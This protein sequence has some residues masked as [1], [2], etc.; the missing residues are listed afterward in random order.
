M[1]LQSPLTLP[2][3]R[4][5]KR[6]K[7]SPPPLKAG[8]DP[9]PADPTFSGQE[10]WVQVPIPPPNSVDP[11]WALSPEVM[12]AL[13]VLDEYIL[14][15]PDTQPWTGL[16][17]LDHLKVT[18]YHTYSLSQYGSSFIQCGMKQFETALKKLNEGGLVFQIQQQYG[19]TYNFKVSPLALQ[20]LNTHPVITAMRVK[21]RRQALDIRN[22]QTGMNGREV[23]Q[24]VLALTAVRVSKR[25]VHYG[26]FEISKLASNLNKDDA[27]FIKALKNQL[28]ELLAVGLLSKYQTH[29][30][31]ASQF[32][33]TDAGLAIFAP[34]VPTQGSP[35]ED[36]D[37]HREM[38]S[39]LERRILSLKTLQDTAR[40]EF[41]KQRIALEASV[42]QQAQCLAVFEKMNTNHKKE[43]EAAT[44]PI[45]QMTLREEI[46]DRD[47]RID[48][49]RSR[50]EHE[51]RQ[52]ANHIEET[53]FYDQQALDTLSLLEETLLVQKSIHAQQQFEATAQRME[54]QLKGLLS[55]REKQTALGQTSDPTWRQSGNDKNRPK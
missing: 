5:P 12:K 2:A 14:N 34:K 37:L 40:A 33:I 24:K 28:E 38:L 13:D 52:L 45:Q 36:A 48:R 7:T 55:E 39:E 11:A 44:D 30:T 35:P 3:Y 23:L 49:H 4:A 6:E 29:R 22:A 15:E 19:N 16:Q 9:P 41:Q 21:A 50:L 1:R 25:E 31:M 17:L 32:K 53:A 42:H 26:F 27:T 47:R 51:T 18:E 54:D 46:A 43:L 8:F 20:L 10:R